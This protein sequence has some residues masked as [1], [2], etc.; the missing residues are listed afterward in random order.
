MRNAYNILELKL[1]L[2]GLLGRSRRKY[3][4]N[5]AINFR[6]KFV[7]SYEHVRDSCVF[8]KEQCIINTFND[9]QLLKDVAACSGIRILIDWLPTEKELVIYLNYCLCGS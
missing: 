7:G 4:N 9:R 3:E 2:K 6:G 8:Q 1:G 5:I